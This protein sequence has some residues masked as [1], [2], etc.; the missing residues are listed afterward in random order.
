MEEFLNR[1]QLDDMYENICNDFEEEYIKKYGTPDEI[2]LSD[3]TEEEL[4]KAIDENIENE[5]VR[6]LI[7]QKMNEYERRKLSE[8]CFWNK[9]YYKL[10]IVDNDNLK[11][12]LHE[13]HE[14]VGSK[15]TERLL[16]NI[17]IEAFF[18]FY[19]KQKEKYLQIQEDYKMFESD[20]NALKDAYPR[21]KDFINENI[22]ADFTIQEQG[23]IKDIWN[24]QNSL[25][26]FELKFA[27]ILGVREREF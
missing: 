11:K 2:I 17:D 19:Q 27:Y 4:T 20:I 3:E 1:K 18:D 15:Y 25:N 7:R 22:F 16:E 8:M 26:L 5:K 14:K 12:E 13:M 23:A 24:L 9:Q 21:V 6:K 10:G